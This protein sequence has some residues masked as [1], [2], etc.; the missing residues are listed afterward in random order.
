MTGE[1][2][3]SVH[4][5]SA[6]AEQDAPVLRS[7]RECSDRVALLEDELRD[8]RRRFENVADSRA[9]PAAKS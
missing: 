4:E 7:V 5:K 2:N 9:R 8:L 6:A 3:E 1:T